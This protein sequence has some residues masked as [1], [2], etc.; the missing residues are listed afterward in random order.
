MASDRMSLAGSTMRGM[1]H[2]S[3]TAV[4]GQK[5]THKDMYDKHK[6][7]GLDQSNMFF[8]SQAVRLQLSMLFGLFGYF[9]VVVIV[10]VWVTLVKPCSFFF[11]PYSP[12]PS[13]PKPMIGSS[14]GKF[15]NTSPYKK[16]MQC[17]K[18]K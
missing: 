15:C 5:K 10:A 18:M 14:T 16:M 13:R 2:R 6:L 7:E 1:L 11:F 4:A 12:S 8:P 3:A 17:N 9:G